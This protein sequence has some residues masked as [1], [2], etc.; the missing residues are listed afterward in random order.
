MNSPRALPQSFDRTSKG[1]TL[2]ELLVVIAIIAILAG[3][4]L[5][6][7]ARAK[8]KAQATAC[9]SNLHQ[10]G[11]AQQIYATDSNDAIPR[12][13]TSLA[14][15]QYSVD[16]GVTSPTDGTP[17]D[18]YAWFNV[19]PPN[20]ASQSLS[21]YFLMP[22]GNAALKYPYP[23]NGLGKIWLCPTAQAPPSA[24]DFLQGGTYGVFS[25]AFDLDLKLLAD[26]G[27]HAVLGN[28][29]VYPAMPKVGN[30]R[31]P[32]AQVMMFEQAFN[33]DTETYT[34]TPSRNGIL[35]ADRWG[36]FS[37][38]HNKQGSIAFLDGHS[39][40]YKRDYVFN[41]ASPPPNRVEKMNPD[42]WWNPNRD[43]P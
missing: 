41:A 27:K 28:S 6:A 37:E 18:P 13:G 15:A 10:W 24:Q 30:I 1:F 12:D 19:L 23:G 22:G 36:V 7:L 20:V 4:L 38:R 9:L 31:F 35:P 26:I 8:A 17:L 11:I 42:I 33:P 29:Y 34:T 43:I 16:T 3:L 21:N 14:G 2:I 25:Y 5:P 40:I 32:S 39:A